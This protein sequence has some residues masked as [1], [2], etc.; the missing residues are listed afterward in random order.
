LHAF[1]CESIDRGGFD[2]AAVV[3]DVGPAE[4]IRHDQHHVRL[5]GM[6]SLGNR[7][8]EQPAGQGERSEYS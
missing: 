4:V 7:E 8:E 3:R 5:F 6:C 2:F 1:R